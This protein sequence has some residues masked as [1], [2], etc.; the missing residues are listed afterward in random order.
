MR[1]TICSCIVEFT[2]VT[3]FLVW[4]S[5]WID[6]DTLMREFL[7][8]RST[9]VREIDT[10]IDADTHKLFIN[11]TLAYGRPL[12]ISSE[13]KKKLKLDDASARMEPTMSNGFWAKQEGSDRFPIGIKFQHPFNATEIFSW[14]TWSK[15]TRPRKEQK[16]TPETQGDKGFRKECTPHSPRRLGEL[17]RHWMGIW[18][19]NHLMIWHELLFHD[20]WIR[21]TFEWTVRESTTPKDIP[22]IDQEIA[23]GSSISFGFCQILINWSSRERLLI[24]DW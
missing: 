8:H 6:S 18:R 12:E 15:S 2:S 7:T 11:L 17:D 5:N 22:F 16:P 14:S 19:A 23:G 24:G 21:T 1:K 9:F 3:S 13:T 10:L 4:N 20:L